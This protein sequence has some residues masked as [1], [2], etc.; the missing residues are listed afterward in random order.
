MPKDDLASLSPSLKISNENDDVVK[1][2]ARVRR[3]DIFRQIEK[4]LNLVGSGPIE[5]NYPLSQSKG[6][7]L[8][9]LG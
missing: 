6:T 3:L 7:L 2:E 8:H 9:E 5:K 4:C 1:N